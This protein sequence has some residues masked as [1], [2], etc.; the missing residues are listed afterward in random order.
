MESGTSSSTMKLASSFDSSRESSQHE[1]EEDQNAEEQAGPGLASVATY[2]EDDLAEPTRS[3]DME[4]EELLEE[5]RKGELA[6]RLT[7]KEWQA[8][9]RGEAKGILRPEK[10]TGNCIMVVLSE[11]CSAESFSAVGMIC[12]DRFVD[13]SLV[14]NQKAYLEEN[15]GSAIDAASTST[16][17][18][19]YKWFWRLSLTYSFIQPTRHLNLKR[20]GMNRCFV[21]PLKDLQEGDSSE[22]LVPAN[23][24]DTAKFFISRLPQEDQNTLYKVGEALSGS[25]VI[26][27]GT[28]CSGTDI[29]LAALKGALDTIS[30]AG[31]PSKGVYNL[32]HLLKKIGSRD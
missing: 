4:P 26:R 14:A 27:V 30:K 12:I 6:V 10:S 5:W 9:C 16:S 17:S 21:L 11:S 20:K 15:L 28:T 2:H 1:E 31:S 19:R 23:L 24:V 18:K 25:G 13:I 3:W 22:R 29:C 7:E 32:F 8:I